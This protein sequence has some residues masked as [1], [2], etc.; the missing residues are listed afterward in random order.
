MAIVKSE[1]FEAFLREPSRRAT[2]FLLYGTDSDLASERARRLVPMLVS[3]AADPFQVVRLAAETLAKDPG[4]L[5]DE[6]SAISMFGGAR[7]IWIDA[8]GRDLSGAIASV[9][10]TLAA[11]TYLVVEA[12]SLRKGAA[13]RTLFETRPDAIALECY[14]AS[15]ASLGEMID[16]EARKAGV[17]VA[18]EARALLVEALAAEPATARVEI[19]KLMLYAEGAGALEAA[20]VAALAAGGGVSPAD[21]LVDLALAGDL[22]GLERAAMHGL[23]DSGDA[24]LA[25]MRL[26]GR[27]ALMLEIRQGGEPE[28][29]QRLPF[30]VKRAVLAQANAFAPETLARRLPALL[31][32]LVSTRRSPALAS[33]SAFRA[34]TA[35]AQAARRSEG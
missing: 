12:D 26:A 33:A 28:R 22:K 3:D 27:V 25:A 16:A 34:L 21:A 19:A 8:G 23:A 15:P 14:P 18:A 31:N 32:L 17:S 6:A 9:A 4:R 13:L 11:E 30:T 20:D 5:A 7:V 2:M 10:D 24:A 29:L 1:R 35:F